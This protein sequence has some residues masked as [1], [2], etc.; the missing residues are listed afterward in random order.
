M[1][2]ILVV[3]DHRLV[4]EGTKKVLENEPDFHVELVTS[5]KDVEPIIERYTY[6]AYLLDWQMPGISGV[7]LGKRILQKQPDAK[8]VMYTGYDIAP[9]FHYLIESGITGFVSKTATSEQLIT[10]IRCAL[11]NEAVVPVHLLRRM[12]LSEVKDRTQEGEPVALS[13]LEQ[14]ILMEV[15]N[16]LGNKEIAKKC[17]ISQRSIE[18]QLSR[19]FA[20][21]QVSSRIEAVE[22]ARKL[23]LISAIHMEY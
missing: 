18:R 1:I 19:I 5:G 10:A 17:H 13:P 6:D 14:E 21:L 8:I 15:A 9:F 2:H 11:R 7:E 12:R 4:G 20:K 3:D 23:G 16:G 22:K